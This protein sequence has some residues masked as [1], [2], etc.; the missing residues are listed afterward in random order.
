MDNLVVTRPGFQIV[1]DLGGRKYTMAAPSYG[2]SAE[3]VELSGTQMRPTAAVLLEETRD[4]LRRAHHVDLVPIIDEWEEAE[5][6]LRSTVMTL[7]GDDS[8]QAKHDLKEARNRFAAATRARQRAEWVVR[9]DVVLKDMRKLAHQ[10]DRQEHLLLVSMCL[11]GWEGEGL[12]PVPDRITP[13]FLNGTDAAPGA[14]LPAGDI[15][16]L[17]AFARGLLNPTAEVAGNSA[18]PS[19]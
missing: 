1:R 4:A 10:M 19:P 18:P 5:D 7:D 16:A 3:L 2:R 15:A 14:A 11:V 8:A 6:G 9:D 12:P 13:E 17:G